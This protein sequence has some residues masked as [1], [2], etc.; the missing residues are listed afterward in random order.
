MSAGG[1]AARRAA[2]AGGGAVVADAELIAL[3]AAARE[4]AYAPYSKFKVGAAVVAG[5][6]KVYVGCNVENASYPL[7]VCAE[8]T[9]IGTAVAAGETEILRVVVIA[10]SEPPASPCGGCRQVIFEFGANA[11]V[12]IASTAGH[13]H[14]TDIRTLLPDGFDGASLRR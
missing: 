5:S 3:A 12:V 13:V 7:T 6:G 4:R 9:A 14:V 11:V 10:D 8:R 2:G 1:R